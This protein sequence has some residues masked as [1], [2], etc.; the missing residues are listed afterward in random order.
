MIA[1]RWNEKPRRSDQGS[2]GDKAC[3]PRTVPKIRETSQLPVC[4]PGDHLTPCAGH[5]LAPCAGHGRL[6]PTPDLARQSLS[7]CAEQ[8]RFPVQRRRLWRLPS[9]RDGRR[10]SCRTKRRH[11]TSAIAAVEGVTG[12]PIAPRTSEEHW[13][14]VVDETA[15]AVFEF[16]VAHKEFAAGYRRAA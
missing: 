4:A 8:A 7:M 2:R 11:T 12:R 6:I 1:R 16:T 13:F 3:R 5:G 9:R 15:S 14:R 10:S